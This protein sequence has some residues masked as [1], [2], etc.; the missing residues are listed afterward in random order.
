M[1]RRVDFLLGRDR[2]TRHLLEYGLCRV[3]LGFRFE[4]VTESD[5]GVLNHLSGKHNRRPRKITDPQDGLTSK[6]IGNISLR[7]SLIG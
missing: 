1:Q 6:D 7:V 2:D 4:L 3:E 5:Y